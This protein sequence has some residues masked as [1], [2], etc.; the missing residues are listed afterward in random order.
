MSALS[1]VVECIL[2][3]TLVNLG[4]VA[5]NIKLY[6]EIMKNYSFEKRKKPKE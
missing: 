4:C 1:L 2:M 3:A 6:T 5:I